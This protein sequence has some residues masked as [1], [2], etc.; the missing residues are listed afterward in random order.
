MIPKIKRSRSKL[1]GHLNEYEDE[2][3]SLFVP[4]DTYPELFDFHCPDITPLAPKGWQM[5][6]RKRMKYLWFPA[7][8]LGVS[9]LEQIEDWKQHFEQYVLIGLNEN[10]APY[11]KDEIDYCMALDYNF[12]PVK[13][14]R[15]IYGEAEYQLKYRNNLDSFS[16]LRSALTEALDW[17]PVHDNERRKLVLTTIPAARAGNNRPLQLIQK[18][19]LS[20]N[21][22]VIEAELLCPKQSMK[23]L[24]LSA[25]IPIWQ[26]LYA[27]PSCVKLNDPVQNR[28]VVIVDDLYQSGSTIWCYAQ[29]L[30]KIGAKCVLGL[31]CVK[32]MKDTDNQ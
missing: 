15:T 27:N 25:K 6:K 26:K 9:E 20:Q 3:R 17:L 22:D 10:I 4:A 7:G 24:E 28:I 8:S 14:A 16:T 11:F 29:Y 23:N 21:I 32:S 30:K 12:D 2:A 5:S 31:A 18:I 1:I 19:G 13:K